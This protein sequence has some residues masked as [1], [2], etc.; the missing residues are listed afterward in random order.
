M[1][2]YFNLMNAIAI[3]VLASKVAIAD[4]HPFPGD[5]EKYQTGKKIFSD[6]CSRCH[7]EN[8]DG[9]GKAVPMYLKMGTSLPSNFRVKFFSIRPKQYLANIVRDGGQKHSLSQYMPPFGSELDNQQ[10]GDVVYFIQKVSVYSNSKKMHKT[11][12][13]NSKLAVGQEH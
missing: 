13:S 8:A 7:G 9:R 11:N 12:A 4:Q 10:I 5:F 6:Y 3:L 2:K 1:H